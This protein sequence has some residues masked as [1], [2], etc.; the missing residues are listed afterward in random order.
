MNWKS[1]LTFVVSFLVFKVSHLTEFETTVPSETQLAILGQ[2]IV[3]DCSFPVDKQWDRM[4]CQIEW[5]FDKEVVHSFYYGQDHLNNQSSRY[6]NRTSLY[7]SDIEKGNASL[8][9]ERA[10]LVDEGNYT[11][12]VHTELGPKRTSVSLKLAAFYPEPRL[13]FSTCASGVELLLTTEGYPRPS[14]QWLTSHISQDTQGLYTVSSTVSLQGAVNKTLT[15]VLKNE[16]LGQEI[17]RNITFLSGNTVDVSPG[18]YQERW[19]FIVIILAVMLK[20]LCN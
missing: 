16:D 6:V 5:K 15:F 14:V 3:L 13:K 19:W 18:V 11:C 8:R 20:Y 2:H 12:T 7:H 1:C 4:S 10:T 9:L 17:R